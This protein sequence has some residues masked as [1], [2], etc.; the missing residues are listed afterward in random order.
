[1]PIYLPREVTA[2]SDNA[3]LKDA[4]TLSSDK[5]AANM[6]VLKKDGQVM[7]WGRNDSEHRP[8]G[9]YSE[10]ET[11]DRAVLGGRALEVSGGVYNAVAVTTAGQVKTWGGT[12]D[13]DYD[14]RFANGV[15]DVTIY[16]G[17]QRMD[18][19][20]NL[21]MTT[22][23]VQQV[24]RLGNLL[25]W[26]TDPDETPA[27]QRETTT[28]ITQWPVLRETEVP[29]VVTSDI[30]LHNVIRNY[31]LPTVFTE[32]SSGYKY[33]TAV[34]R[35]MKVGSTD[36][37]RV[38]EVLAGTRWPDGYHPVTETNSVDGSVTLLGYQKDGATDPEDYL[39]L[40]FIQ[41]GLVGFDGYTLTRIIYEE[42]GEE[43]YSYFKDGSTDL[44]M[45]ED[46][47]AGTA[48]NLEGYE[49]VSSADGTILGYRTIGSTGDVELT[50][51]D[52][53]AGRVHC[54]TWNMARK[55]KIM[56]ER[57]SMRKVR[58]PQGKDNG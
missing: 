18:E 3:V 14:T 58:A 25:Y 32:L 24:D 45:L 33:G 56:D 17:E 41:R 5:I 20:G 54:R 19:F 53:R 7:T 21:K 31:D 28:E 35:F 8:Y 43:Y 44:V 57:P 37:V 22:G 12:V 29:D 46:V 47:L 50:I 6:R 42:D 36:A 15:R 4:L 26:V 13:A 34:D 40:R 2:N 9:G 1:M 48:A 49:T 39:L 23:Y 55:L 27:A 51:A 16:A 11:P 10:L 52:L 30:Y 38:D